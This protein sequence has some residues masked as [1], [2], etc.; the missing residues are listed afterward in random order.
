MSK[1]DAYTIDPSDTVAVALE[2]VCAG[3][4]ARVRIGIEVTAV[5]LRSDIPLGHKFAVVA[6]ARGGAVVKYGAVMAR[7][8][9]DIAIGEHVHVHNAASNRARTA[10]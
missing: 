9:T 2:D 6:M 8:T 10:Q 4:V 3:T 7:A 5:R 1:V